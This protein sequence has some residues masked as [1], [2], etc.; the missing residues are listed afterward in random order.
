MVLAA[1]DPQLAP[2]IGGFAALIA[3]LGI[4]ERRRRVQKR[5][6]PFVGSSDLDRQ[7]AETILTQ[8]KAVLEAANARAVWAESEERRCEEERAALGEKLRAHE[9]EK[10]RRDWLDSQPRRRRRPGDGTTRPD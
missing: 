10:A 6:H 8:W 2:I 1:I 4:S 5:A 7:A 3:A 9:W